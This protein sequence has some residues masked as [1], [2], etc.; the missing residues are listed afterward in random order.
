MKIL[1]GELEPTVGNVATE[2]HVRVGQLRQD[3]FAYEEYSVVDTV[4]MGDAKLAE[5]KQ[6]RAVPDGGRS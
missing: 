6:E 1:A 3:Q 4:I 2:P 5:I